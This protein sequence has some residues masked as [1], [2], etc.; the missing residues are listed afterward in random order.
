M[1]QF[2][3]IAVSQASGPVAAWQVWRRGRS[4]VILWSRRTFFGH[5]C[6]SRLGDDGMRFVLVG[7]ML[8]AA[9][10]A[11]ADDVCVKPA[12]VQATLDRGLAFLAKDAVAWREEHKCASCHH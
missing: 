10:L 6:P 11:V 5:A 1:V 12:D 2:L 3:P 8:I 9:R 7:L 4:V